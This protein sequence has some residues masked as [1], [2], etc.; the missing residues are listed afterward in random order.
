MYNMWSDN[1]SDPNRELFAGQV[2]NWVIDL[3]LFDFVLVT[4][5]PNKIWLF[6]TSLSSNVKCV[7]TLLSCV[8]PFRNNQWLLVICKKESQTL[9]A[10][11]FTIT[12]APW[13]PALSKLRSPFNDSHVVGVICLVINTD[14][15]N[16]N[17]KSY[18][19]YGALNLHH[20]STHMYLNIVH[21]FCHA[22]YLSVSK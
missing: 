1:F 15:E 13:F 8:T 9:K 16:T 14:L 22:Y 3:W 2:K 19:F 18:T 17:D 6:L 10:K 12:V 7:R 20:E 4:K 11:W 21:F 5:L